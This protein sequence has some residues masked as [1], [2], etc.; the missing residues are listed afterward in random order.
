MVYRLTK[1]NCKKLGDIIEFSN[2]TWN[3]KDFFDSKFP[4][5][6]INAIDTL[7]GEIKNITYYEK[8][9]APSRAKMIVRENDIIIST[10]RPHRGAISWI[11]KNKNGF[12]AS[13]GF[14]VLR[15]LKIKEITREYL[16]CILRT[17]LALKQML[18]RS[19]GGN[20][21]AITSNE[22][23]KIIIPI[24]P[25][26][27]QQKIIKEIK[28]AYKI[29]KQK[30]DEA[31]ELL[32]SIN[33]YILNE[34]GIKIPE[35]NEKMTFTVD[36]NS[37]MGG[38]LDPRY[39]KPFF[40]EFENELMKRNDIEYL[41][42]ISKYIGSGAT[43]KAGGDDYT[44]KEEG[45]PFIRIVNL[46]N[47]TIE[48]NEDTLYIKKSVH[49]G[50][51]KRTQLNPNDVLLTM[52]GTIGLSVVVPENLGEANINQAIARIV[53]NDGINHLYISTVL[54]SPIGRIQT[55]RYS[56]PSVQAN[57]NLNEIKNIKIPL[58]LLDIQ[59]KIADEVKRRIKRAEQLQKEAKEVL[60]KA[61]KEVEN[62]ILNGE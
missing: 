53:L 15:D 28:R 59:N 20:Y 7:T 27:I 14:A 48:L 45:I 58:P 9:K 21:P 51:L 61:K 29:K 4:Y 33:D 56:R 60:E 17:K 38:R 6:E 26:E 12:I 44:T 31:K 16:Y 55:N 40:L 36:A 30:E 41:G 42:E 57:I 8:N 22:L 2:E 24:P 52:A 50:M 25:I 54:N 47:N 34:L 18:Q 19:S 62:I 32:N 35:L 43:P 5:I 46:K 37:I 1:L 49:E 13:T 11:D 10:T 23:K 3:Q 39:Y